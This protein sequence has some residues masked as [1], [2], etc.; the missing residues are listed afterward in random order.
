[1]FMIN[2]VNIFIYFLQPCTSCAKKPESERSKVG[3]HHSV[4]ILISIELLMISLHLTRKNPRRRHLGYLQST[5]LT[6]L[7][8]N[9]FF[10]ALMFIKCVNVTSIF[11]LINIPKMR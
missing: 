5:P 11:S 1:M 2:Q 3:L 10:T 6:L 9:L 7:D 4:H 8:Y